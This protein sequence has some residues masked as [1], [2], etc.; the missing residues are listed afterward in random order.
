MSAATSVCNLTI[1]CILVAIYLS[2][3]SFS[4]SAD[5][6]MNDDRVML[7]GFYWESMRHNFGPKPIGDKR[8]YEIVIDAAPQIQEAR[9]D[10]VW[11]PPPSDAGP[12]DEGY[13]PQQLFLLANSYGTAEMHRAAL[14]ALYKA[15]AEPVADI[16]INH[17]NGT[18]GW[19]KFKFPE[20]GPWAICKNDEAFYHDDSELKG[21]PEAERGQSE[22]P[23]DGYEGYRDIDHSNI[24]VRKDIVKYL[25]Y[26][27]SFGYRGWRYDMVTRFDGKWIAVY[28]RETNPTFSVGEYWEHKD[29]AQ[30]R[31]WIWS[32]A[33][34]PEA[35]GNEHLATCSSAFDFPGQML[36]G[37]NKGK[38]EA[39]YA[40]QNGIG[41]TTDNTDGLLWRN[42]TVTFLENHD[43]AYHT[44]KVSG[45]HKDSSADDFSKGWEV[46]QAYAYILTHPGVPCVFWKHYFDWGKDLQSRIKALINARKVAGIH[47]ASYIHTQDLAR[48]KGVY[49]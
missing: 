6:P 23:E 9:F 36:L 37:D 3:H 8:W 2:A 44:E 38:Y 21:L 40:H 45:K 47:A 18:E 22:T 33:T 30:L 26:L 19:A 42:R 20:W 25:R 29:F 41:L 28:N 1:Y 39:W 35:E 48:K 46:E 24:Q 32:T 5:L 43:T 34:K 7:Q 12:Y 16:V 10:M 14:A 11:M 4:H 13:G 49:G 17:R 31:G 15:G 27:K